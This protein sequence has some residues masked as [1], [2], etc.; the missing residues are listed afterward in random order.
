MARRMVLQY[1]CR[2]FFPRVSA[3][4]KT[5]WKKTKLCPNNVG[6]FPALNSRIASLT[7]LCLFG[8]RIRVDPQALFMH[9]Q[10]DGLRQRTRTLSHWLT[11]WI[12]ARFNSEF[13]TTVQQLNISRHF[14]FETPSCKLT[15]NWREN[16]RFAKH[17]DSTYHGTTWPL[18][19][20]VRYVACT[21]FFR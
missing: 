8:W 4:T 14:D 7:W 18:V 21:L 11:D 13:Q 19:Y 1:T 17:P 20:K 9:R 6:F 16:L 12:I 3:N 10:V 15:L 5:N 2:M